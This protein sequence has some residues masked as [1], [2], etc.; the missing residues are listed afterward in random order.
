M[1]SLLRI[2]PCSLCGT[3]EA[4]VA[5]TATDRLEQSEQKFQIVRCCGCGVMRTLPEMS[6][7]ELGKFYP[8][9]YWGGEPTEEWLQLT[10]ADKLRALKQCGLSGG[11]ILDVG[12]GAG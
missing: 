12:C 6:D 11:R 2:S 1:N 9:D 7:E 4:S 5:F 3:C 10:Q 8:E